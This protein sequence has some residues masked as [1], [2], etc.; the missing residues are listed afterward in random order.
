MGV[1]ATSRPPTR[2]TEDLNEVVPSPSSTVDSV[3][4]YDLTTIISHQRREVL[5][6][7]E[8]SFKAHHGHSKMI[9]RNARLLGASSSARFSFVGSTQSPECTRQEVEPSQRLRPNDQR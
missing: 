2:L 1:E 5:R 6:F 7:S 8:Q 3:T 9:E 4:G